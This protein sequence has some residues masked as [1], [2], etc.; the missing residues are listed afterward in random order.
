MGDTP[1][2]VET[3]IIYRSVEGGTTFSLYVKNNKG[4]FSVGDSEP[5]VTPEF[6]A[7]GWVALTGTYDGNNLKIYLG[8]DLVESQSSVS[9]TTGYTTV[10]NE[11]GLFIGKSN[12]GAIKGLI[13]EIRIF[14]IALGANNINGSGGNGNPAENFPSSISQYIRGQWSFYEISSG[15]VLSDLSTL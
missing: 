6:N 9:T 7:F 13:D 11:S 10:P 1:A 12:T 14:D 8:G 15:D 2:G 4:Y 3:P 5:V